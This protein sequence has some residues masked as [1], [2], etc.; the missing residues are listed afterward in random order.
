MRYSEFWEL[1]EEV[2]GSAHGRELVATLVVGALENR[3][4]AAALEDGADPREVWHAMCDE[5]QIP[6]SQRWGADLRRPAPPRR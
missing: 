2:L 6:Q 4:P 5:L 1:V 3:T